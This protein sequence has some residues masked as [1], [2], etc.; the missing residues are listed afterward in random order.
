MVVFENLHFADS[1][2]KLLVALLKVL[3]VL[4]SCEGCKGFFKRT[5]RKDLHY[6]CRD[7]NN[8]TVDK[9]QRNR[10]QHCRYMKCLHQGMK[11]EGKKGSFIYIQQSTISC[12]YIYNLITVINMRSLLKSYSCTSVKYL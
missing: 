1:K 3:L 4:N 10:C 11:R 2:L 9:R 7:E 12:Y 5:V 6:T 8:C